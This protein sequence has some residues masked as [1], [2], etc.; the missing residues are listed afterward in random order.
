KHDYSSDVFKCFFWT[1]SKDAQISLNPKPR[2]G[3]QPQHIEIN[4]PMI[5][6]EI[7]LPPVV[8]LQLSALR[9]IWLNF[10]HLSDYCTSFNLKKRR[11]ATFNIL[12]QT[13]REWHKRKEIL[14]DML[15]ECTK[16]TTLTLDAM[17]GIDSK[18]SPRKQR[19]FDI[20]K[21]YAEYEDNLNKCRKQS[22]GPA[23]YNLLETDVNLRKYRIIGGVYCIDYLDIPGQ[24]KRLNARSF[25]RTIISPDT[26]THKDFFQTYKPPP[27]VQPGVRRLPEEIEA[28][29]R[30]IEAALDKLALVTLQ[31]P[32]SV[33]WFEPPIACR[34]ETY[35]DTLESD[36]TEGIKPPT[37][38]TPTDH[39]TP[40][41]TFTNPSPI[42][43][44]PRFPSKQRKRSTQKSPT[45]ATVHEVTD[46]DM[47]NIPS[48]IDIH[49][50]FKDFV[51]PRLPYGFNVHLNTGIDCVTLKKDNSRQPKVLFFARHHSVASCGKDIIKSAEHKSAY[52]SIHGIRI[53]EEFLD[54]NEPR[55]LFPRFQFDKMLK[56]KDLP[57]NQKDI[58][59]LERQM[60]EE[61]KIQETVVA[62]NGNGHIKVNK[63]NGHQNG[64]VNGNGNDQKNGNGNGRCVENEKQ[65]ESVASSYS[66]S[67]SKASSES[68]YRRSSKGSDS[69]KKDN[70]KEVKKT[71][72]FSELIEDLE[73]LCELQKPK[74]EEVLN[75]ISEKLTPT[76]STEGSQ[77]EGATAVAA[78]ATEEE[79]LAKSFEANL[80]Q[81]AFSYF[82]GI[83]FIRDMF[84]KNGN[85]SKETTK[86]AEDDES[87]EYDDEDD[88][89]E[90][91]E[92]PNENGKIVDN[93]NTLGD[94]SGSG[95][96]G[97]VAENS[98][99]AGD[100]H[101]LFSHHS[102]SESD[103]NDGKKSKISNIIALTK[104]KWS[105]RDVH[106]TKFNEDKLSIQFRTGRLGIFGFALNRYSNMP[107][108]A[109]EIKPDF[110]NPGSVLFSFT[111]S[112]VSLDMSIT[113]AGYCMNNFQGGTTDAIN[114]M[115]GKTLSLADLKAT[116]ISSAV[117]IFPDE[118]AFCYTEGS[119]E[120]NYVMEMHLY[121]CMSTLALSHNF[122]WSRWNLL[123]GSR[124]AV[125]LLRELIENRKVTP[126]AITI[127]NHITSGNQNNNG[128]QIAMASYDS[129]I[130]SVEKLL[131]VFTGKQEQASY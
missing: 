7:T 6:M 64:K 56:F 12:L 4:F 119:C 124:T 53:N 15:D 81:P 17:E 39:A 41:S 94:G 26:L 32:D 48:D 111:A 92:N 98:G 1:F 36:L 73:R 95:G 14:Q 74:Q 35:I 43:C 19:S 112:I 18:S 129:V 51:V 68:E 65:T 42:K 5:E 77:K 109:W 121:V 93:L 70:P 54:L 86:E 96:G 59:S 63:T 85:E 122:S 52:D 50:L 125:L 102:Q 2:V 87:S 58:L 91:V 44:S 69:E 82:T 123:A 60:S 38:A 103:N 75:Q 49:S 118:D 16:E 13:K 99:S 20:D 24:D 130:E 57:I 106:D 25:I 76:T 8:Q 11:P 128:T 40:M 46:F 72:M 33:I 80:M 61:Q 30:M 55:E 105:T 62:G 116:L 113:S 90:Y 45:R 131:P 37:T 89:D 31:L 83:S 126:D 27:P 34:W 23:A 88:Y 114:D 21:V 100:V 120:K 79:E 67:I 78:A 127:N 115:I 29:M 110:K 66:K 3:E 117:D 104:G 107:Y 22:I 84:A 108:Q 10:D 9:G 28:E 97:G 47:L 101:G 71:Y